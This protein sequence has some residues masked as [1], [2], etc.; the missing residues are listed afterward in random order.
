MSFLKRYFARDREAAAAALES[1]PTPAAADAPAPLPTGG[2][3]PPQPVV[4]T[5]PRVKFD[6]GPDV[7]F[8]ARP[9]DAPEPPAS[10]PAC[11]EPVVGKRI[12]PYTG[13]II[14]A[15][16]TPNGAGAHR[17]LTSQQTI[18][19]IHASKAT[20]STT[21]ALIEEPQALKSGKV[22]EDPYAQFRKKRNRPA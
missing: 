9:S 4:Q 18:D 16:N 1:G 7:T 21:P 8:D 12:D 15:S 20:A 11:A 6:A 10:P 19:R 3:M 14:D 17:R 22:Y 2:G 5:R 13:Y